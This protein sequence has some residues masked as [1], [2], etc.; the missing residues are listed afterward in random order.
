[1]YLSDA[2]EESMSVEG[3]ASGQPNPPADSPSA[4]DNGL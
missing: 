4:E 3:S 2:V 1:M